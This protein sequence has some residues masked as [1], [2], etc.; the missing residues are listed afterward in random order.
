MRNFK[1]IQVKGEIRYVERL[2]T[3]LKKS[4]LSSGVKINDYFGYFFREDWLDTWVESTVVVKHVEKASTETA[5]HKKLKKLSQALNS[6]MNHGLVSLIM[7]FKSIFRTKI[8]IL[9]KNL[10]DA[11]I[12]Q[13][14]ERITTINLSFNRSLPRKWTNIIYRRHYE[15]QP[16]Y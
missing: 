9:F 3:L 8:P 13:L 1:E 12:A 5:L 10:D 11:H 4:E 2:I 14:I 7:D 16:H 15:L 6:L